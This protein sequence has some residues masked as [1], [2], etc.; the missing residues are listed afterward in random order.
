MQS[1]YATLDDS[2]VDIVS[3]VKSQIENEKE[4]LQIAANILSECDSVTLQDVKEYF[5]TFETSGMLDSVALLLP[6]YD[7]VH[8]KG[9]MELEDHF[10]FELESIKAPYLSDVKYMDT[11]IRYNYWAVP[12]EKDKEI[13]GILY[14]IINL[15]SF[16]EKYNVTSYNGDA[17]LYVI[18]GSSGKLIMNSTGK[19]NKQDTSSSLLKDVEFD[20]D[21]EDFLMGR[22]GHMD[23]YSVIRKERCY[24][25]YKPLGIKNWM[26]VLSVPKS[27]AFHY[28]NKIRNIMLILVLFEIV[29]LVVYGVFIMLKV[30]KETEKREKQLAQSVFMFDVQQTLFDAHKNS[31]LIINALEKVSDMLTAETAFLVSSDGAIIQDVY[32]WGKEGE[33]MREDLTGENINNSI[34][35]IAAMMMRGKSVLYYSPD[36]TYILE[37][38]D[39]AVLYEYS[40]KNIMIAPVL[41]TSNRLSGFIGVINMDT[42]WDDTIIL[43]CVAANF[44]MALTNLKSFRLVQR[45]GTIDELTGLQNRNSYQQAVSS[46]SRQ[47]PEKFC[48]IYLDANGLHEMNNKYGHK[49]GDEMLKCIGANLL[50][51][52]S[53]ENSYRIGGDEFVVFC[54][55][56]DSE[57]MDQKIYEFAKQMMMH[58]YYVSIGMAC[59]DKSTTIQEAISEAEKRMYE[60]KRL[61]YKSLG[62]SSKAR[63]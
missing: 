2:T 12:I 4:Q 16:Y 28:A 20:T 42:R 34:P 32:Y 33:G 48:C 22:S 63:I 47:K 31:H 26:V 18:D 57:T 24:A 36:K 35:D 37:Q 13:V 45:M 14:G 6:E 60:D 27:T 54:T 50:Q 9:S 3:G 49:A 39:K 1:C 25:Y 41:D 8:L 5:A 11:G 10:N 40:A 46:Y 58:E 19:N 56:L 29:C 52:F 38:K 44:M 15:N 23:Y 30:Q 51:I 17:N 62:D 59:M 7:L 21:I 43:E 53:G 55:G 61:Y